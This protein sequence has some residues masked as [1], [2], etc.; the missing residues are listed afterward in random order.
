MCVCGVA[1]VDDCDSYEELCNF[2]STVSSGSPVKHFIIHARK[3][4]LKGLVRPLHT[5]HAVAA[6]RSTAGLSPAWSRACSYHLAGQTQ[7]HA[8]ATLNSTAPARK[9]DS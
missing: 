5:A 9:E 1:G 2:I 7:L 3:C 8:V 6:V 4:H